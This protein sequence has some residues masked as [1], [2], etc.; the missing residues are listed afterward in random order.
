MR[1]TERA[2]Q[3][4]KPRPE[5]YEA[6]DDERRS[7]GVRVSVSGRK[8]F[9]YLFRVRGRQR[10]LTL[11]PWPEMSLA[12]ARAAHAEAFATLARGLDPA[13]LKKAERQAARQT[14]TVGEL[15]VLYLKR[16]ARPK[17]RSWREDERMLRKDVLPRWG[18][19]L[20]GDITR[21]DIIALLNRIVDRG[22]P[23]QANRT[24]ACIRKMF[25]FA[26][27]QAL[28]GV[29]PCQL[30]DRPGFEQSR[31]RVLSE[32]EIRRLWPALGPPGLSLAVGQA[33]KLM[34]VTAQRVGEVCAL[35][36]AE[37]DLERGWWTLPAAKAKNKLAHRVPLS[38][39][40]LE[41]LGERPQQTGYVFPARR[42]P[43]H[44]QGASVPQAVKARRLG[45]TDWTPRDLRRT[46]ASHMAGM[47]VPRLVVA[48]VLNHAER[49]VTAVYDRHSYD[50]EKREAL[51]AW[52]A[53]LQ[54]IVP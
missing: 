19:R 23:V 50:A 7:F 36:W 33:L 5:R 41:V 39:L 13:A 46:A 54:E 30:I 47:G 21:A 18:E 43:W 40:A 8:S 42:E 6:F 25:N 24:F 34:L 3:A 32:Q 15:V 44:L 2:L 20:A 35:E 14:G 9:V 11:G 26:V 28:L 29:S 31:Q 16:H 1:L 52:A 27:K 53:K 4:L 22:A 10:R 17:K 12:A 49:G 38:G 51:D 37:L 45:V 48:R